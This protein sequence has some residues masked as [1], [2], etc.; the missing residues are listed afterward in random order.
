MEI[1]KAAR[2]RR[3]EA[4]LN[5]LKNNASDPNL[6]NRDI[7]ALRRVGQHDLA[8]QFQ[9]ATPQGLA[10]TADQKE[11]DKRTKATQKRHADE[12]K[13]TADGAK[14]E[15]AKQATDYAGDFA[16]G[17]LGVQA[18]HG[19]TPTKADIHKGLTDSGET[20]EAADAM[21]DA[22]YNAFGDKMVGSVKERARKDSSTF[23]EA[24]A[25]LAQD[26]DD[27]AKKKADSEAKQVEDDRKHQE[28]EANKTRLEQAD[29]ILAGSG[30]D[31]TTKDALLRSGLN[32][33]AVTQQL[34]NKLQAGDMNAEDAQ[35]TA[36]EKV[37]KEANSILDKAHADALN[38]DPARNLRGPQTIATADLSR[39]VQD[40][41]DPKE[42]LNV[43]KNM[44]AHLADL[45]TQGMAPRGG[46]AR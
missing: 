1:E 14:R 37:G 6:L 34:A 20:K 16:K 33:Q 46:L 40:G 24:Q 36:S 11:N 30:S 25:A 32:I 3:E 12:A 43:S 21:V 4:A 10:I 18:L 17:E 9:N 8:D 23:S 5:N 44:E 28:R 22:V 41:Q 42:L 29:A 45:V 2:A 38:L 13:R 35:K 15:A 26:I 31:A 39:T 7:A 27:K 19:I